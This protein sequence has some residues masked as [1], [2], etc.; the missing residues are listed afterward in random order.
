MIGLACVA[1]VPVCEEHSGCAQLGAR[2]KQLPI[3]ARPKCAKALHTGR[4]AM[5]GQSDWIGFGFT[6]LKLKTALYL[7]IRNLGVALK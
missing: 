4:L 2:A 1:N 3:C 7:E 6:T 5:I